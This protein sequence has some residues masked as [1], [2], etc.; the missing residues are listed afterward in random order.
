MD[1]PLI[2]TGMVVCSLAGKDKGAVYVVTGSLTAP[3]VWVADGRKYK[4][5]K[6]KKK[7]CRHLQV[8][9]T[10]V[11]GMD[12]GSVRISNEWIRPVLKRARVESIREVT[13]V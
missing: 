6:P 8:L 10:S 1:K 13:H 5:E 4:V 3:Y 7:N 9:G 2:S 11:S 12:A